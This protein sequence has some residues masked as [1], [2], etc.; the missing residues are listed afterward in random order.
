MAP[1]PFPLE[2]QLTG[3][4]KTGQFFGGMGLG[5]AGF[6]AIVLITILAINAL[7]PALGQNS[8]FIALVPVALFVGF[9]VVMSFLLA[10]PRAR[11]LGYGLL[12]ALVA[13]PVIAVV[14]C[15][16]ILAASTRSG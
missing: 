8:G 12:A 6:V 1:V 10:K 5:L 15:V 14:G 16:V 3:G 11:W 2:R 7:G 13:L 9:I 4:Q